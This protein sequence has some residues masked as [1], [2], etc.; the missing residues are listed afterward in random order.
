MRSK[1]L[2]LQVDQL[3]D[4]TESEE[5]GLFRCARTIRMFAHDKGW[6]TAWARRLKR[7]YGGGGGRAGAGRHPARIVRTPD[8]YLRERMHDLTIF[9][10]A[11]CAPDGVVAPFTQRLAV[12]TPSCCAQHGARRTSADMTAARFAALFWKKAENQPCGHCCAGSWHSGGGAGGG[13]H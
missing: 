8:A 10:I 5:R 2:H 9:P 1:Q 4:G 6:V 7:A 12:P 11:R 13:P 3:L